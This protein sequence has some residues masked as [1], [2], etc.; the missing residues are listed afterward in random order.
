MRLFL[1]IR[2]DYKIGLT[3][4]NV[5]KC[6]SI[7]KGNLDCHTVIDNQEMYDHFGRDLVDTYS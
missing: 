7:L 4:D 2:T 5:E 6:I 3:E 1:L